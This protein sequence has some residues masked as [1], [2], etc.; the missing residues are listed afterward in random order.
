M[1]EI[2]TTDRFD[3]WLIAQN[4][5]T[6][7]SVLAALIVLRTKGPGLPRPWADTIKGARYSNIKELR[8]QCRGEPIR[9][10]FAFDPRRAAIVLCAGSKAGNEKRFYA[11]MISRAEQEYANYLKKPEKEE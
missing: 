6:R 10:F 4:D 7:A 3:E 8:I 9:A 5:H 1:W 2:K 11:E